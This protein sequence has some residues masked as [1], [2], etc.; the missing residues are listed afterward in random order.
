LKALASKKGIPWTRPDTR[1]E[2]AKKWIAEVQALG[3]RA[4]SETSNANAIKRY[5]R[6]LLP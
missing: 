1:E 5:F 2:A 3:V 4:V 6:T